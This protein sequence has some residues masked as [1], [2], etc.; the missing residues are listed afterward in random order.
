VCDVASPHGPGYIGSHKT[1]YG[2]AM[3]LPIL[4][5]FLLAVTRVMAQLNDSSSLAE[6][7]FSQL[8]QRDPNPL[9]EKALSINPEQW[10]HGETEHFIYHFVHGY[11]ATPVSVEAEFHY[12]VVAKEL[13]REEPATQTKSHVYI[14]ERAEDWQQ[15]QGVGELEKWTGGIH[16]GGSLFIVR[17]PHVKFSG[18]E[19]GHEIVHLVM[20]RFYPDGIPIWFNEGI[21]Q[22]ISKGAHASFQRARGYIAKPH[23]TTIAAGEFIPIELL[24][25]M[26][27][28]PN[29]KV[30]TFY[31]ESER[32]VRFLAAA[33]H[34]SFLLL[35]DALGRHQPC[36]MAVA[37]C[38]AG[39]FSTLAVLSERFREYAQSDFGTSVP[40][41][42]E[43]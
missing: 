33:D 43:N 12:R 3:R 29:D 5:V 2:K 27:R 7:D 16:S 38:Y 28:V 25:N 41:P 10:K 21:A 40:P 4:A 15:F 26:T 9:G 11:V 24:T 13:E 22:Y 35:V 37:Q 20:H 17:D 19:L 42:S 18:N 34:P 8:S 36:E 30:S 1:G 23:S 32:L 6:V 31:D 39:K 14:F